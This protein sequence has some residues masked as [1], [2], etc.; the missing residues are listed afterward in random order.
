M[1]RMLCAAAVLACLGLPAAASAQVANG[2]TRDKLVVSPSW[3]AEHLNDRDLVILQVGR[4]ETYDTAHIPGA[5]FVNFD[6][7]ALAAPMDH[8]KPDHVMLEMPDVDSLRRQLAALGISDRSRVVVVPADNYWS[9]STRIVLTLDYA[10]LSNVMWLNGG[11]KGWTDNG[12]SLTADVP[13]VKPGTLSALKIHPV[14][15][16]E[17]FVL[18]HVRTPGFA[19]VDARNRNFYDGIP[20]QRASDGPAPKLGHI[21]GA[22][23]APYDQFAV[24]DAGKGETTLKSAE[25]I[26]ALFNAAGVKPGDTIIGYCHIGQQATA[27]LFAARTLGHNVLLYDGSFT[28]WQKRD[29]PVENPAA[30]KKQDK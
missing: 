11:V 7:G 26:E 5:R 20:P 27:M 19:I 17:Q 18:A 9:P 25:D 1:K 21:P 29:L 12:R 13:E 14:V 4:K 22:V 8:S 10:G 2:S 15:V 24:G 3:L 28:E 16:D 23:S 6:A 30:G